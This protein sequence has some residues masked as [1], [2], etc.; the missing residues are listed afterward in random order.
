MLTAVSLSFGSAAAAE[1][2]LRI[3]EQLRF[4]SVI[5]ADV[6]QAI[7]EM[8]RIGPED[9]AEIRRWGLTH[10]KLS[11]RYRYTRAEQS[12]TMR[13]AE[14]QL[15][16]KTVLP[17]WENRSDAA[18]DM[19]SNWAV[20]SRA[21][22]AHEEGHANIARQCAQALHARLESIGDAETCNELGDRIK[23]I[24]SAALDRCDQDHATYDRRTRNGYLEGLNIK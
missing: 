11:W 14:V 17:V 7:R 10:S 23:R 22:A 13:D 18:A 16:L 1:V 2:E 20:L 8:N 12:C 19:Q 5:A 4:Y 3:D 9:D 21:L 15:R 24:G 6:P